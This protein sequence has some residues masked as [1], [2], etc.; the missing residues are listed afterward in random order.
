MGLSRSSIAFLM[1]EAARRPFSGRILMLGLQGILITE[2]EIEEVAREQGVQLRP[3]SQTVERQALQPGCASA[4]YL[5]YRLGFDEVLATDVSEFEGAD[6][7]L[8]LNQL[9]VAPD[10]KG[11]YDVVLDGGTLEHVFHLPNAL[12]NVLDFTAVGGR[13]I[14]IGPSSN[15][16]DHGFYMFSPTL[17]WDFFTANGLDIQTFYLLRYN[18]LTAARERWLYGEYEPG[19]LDNAT[20]TLDVGSYALSLVVEKPTEVGEIKIPQQ[21]MYK[22]IWSA[23]EKSAGQPQQ[24]P[25]T[26]VRPKPITLWRSGPRKWLFHKLPPGLRLW[27][28]AIRRNRFPLAKQRW[29]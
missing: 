25:A 3:P 2:E 5:F 8:D 9:C 15:H 10:Q 1:A 24:A 26:A 7:V 12:Q 19:A 29:M 27:L 6:L 28:K 20:G 14:H 4:D 23:A 11:Q 21:S 13:F 16:L 17:F 22:R 18:L